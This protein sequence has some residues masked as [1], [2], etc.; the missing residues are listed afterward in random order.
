M[1]VNPS[2]CVF[3]SQCGGACYFLRMRIVLQKVS[4]ASVSNETRLLGDILAGY[5]LFVCVMQGD[6]EEQV[7][8]AVAKVLALRL[9]PSVD[10][11]VH[12]DRTIADVGGQILVVSQF[13]LSADLQKGNRP[14][15][16][17]AADRSTALELYTKFVQKLR[18]SSLV[19]N[20]GEFGAYMS[21]S[22]IND[23]PV[24]LSFEC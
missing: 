1:S 24:T 10:G 16:T 15:Y 12:N 17:A 13:T 23:G 20:E 2:F 5:V 19:V 21:V 9:W 4:S 11:S 22:L 6:T 7:G 14:D 8:K 3:W 18:E